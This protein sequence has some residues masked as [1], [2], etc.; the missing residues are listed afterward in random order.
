MIPVA[1]CMEQVHHEDGGCT[2]PGSGLEDA[3]T[4]ETLDM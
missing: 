3:V 2:T 4:L 1:G